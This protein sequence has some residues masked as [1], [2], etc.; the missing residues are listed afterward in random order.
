MLCP[1]GMA[2]EEVAVQADDC[3]EENR[4][5]HP[6]TKEEREKFAEHLAEDP[7][8][9]E[10]VI[11]SKERQEE[12]KDQIRQD[13]VEEPDGVH[14]SLY[15]HFQHPEE[16]PIHSCSNQ[17]GY[18]DQGGGGH[19]CAGYGHCR[20]VDVLSSSCDIVEGHIHVAFIYKA[21]QKERD[22]EMGSIYLPSLAF[23][24]G[25]MEFPGILHHS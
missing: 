25:W 23:I 1:D 13:Q 19:I 21:L 2:G 14:S 10:D 22:A 12:T 6:Q 4:G 9:T 15:L 18:Q 16:K 5:E 11:D 24:L 3:E 20:V 17:E 7:V 8:E